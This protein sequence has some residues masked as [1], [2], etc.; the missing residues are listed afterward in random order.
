[1]DLGVT[2][3]SSIMNVAPTAMYLAP[4]NGTVSSFNF[5]DPMYYDYNF[6]NE[7][8]DDFNCETHQQMLDFSNFEYPGRKETFVPINHGE[9]VKIIF[10]V[11]LFVLSMTGNILVLLVF[12]HND[13]MRS[14][15][16]QHLVNLAVADLL[17]ATFCMW[18]HLVRH[19]TY[20]NYVLPAIVCK[21]EG[22]IQATAVTA[23]VLTLTV[24]SFTRL[25]VVMYPLEVRVSTHRACRVIALVWILSAV[26]SS[27]F[28]IY[29]ELYSFQWLNFKS[30]HCDEIWPVTVVRDENGHCVNKHELQKIFYTVFTIVLYFLPVLVM[31]VN[32]SL[33]GWHLCMSQLP[34]EHNPSSQL[35]SERRRHKGVK[36]VVVVLIVFVV[37]W[38]PLQSIILYGHLF[39]SNKNL[40]HDGFAHYEYASYFM[41]HLNSALNPIIYCGFNDKFRQGVLALFCRHRRG[42]GFHAR[43]PWSWIRGT[44]RETVLGNDTMNGSASGKNS[45][46]DAITRTTPPTIHSTLSTPPTLRRLS[47]TPPPSPT[48]PN[49]FLL[50]LNPSRNSRNNS[51]HQKNSMEVRTLSPQ[52]DTNHI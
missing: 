11:I 35:T 28:A 49:S 32:Y 16:N 46:S 37:C 39:W 34:G 36:M 47:V 21:L 20:P 17:V 27:P 22:F 14:T 9:I 7:S 15:I 1:M 41:A 24:I 48:S 10:Y 52:R 43:R 38:T 5:T 18:V 4:L 33:V 19:L 50:S 25:A 12:Y 31:L 13:N 30:W 29:R 8:Q 3:L 44:T 2:T 51:E 26:L 6:S 45:H 40:L 23:S 42:Q